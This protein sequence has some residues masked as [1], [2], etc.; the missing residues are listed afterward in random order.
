M[1]NIGDQVTTTTISRKGEVNAEG[2]SQFEYIGYPI[3]RKN[4]FEQGVV[5]AKDTI[6]E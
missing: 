3:F 6:E 5:E 4:L 2:K 1:I